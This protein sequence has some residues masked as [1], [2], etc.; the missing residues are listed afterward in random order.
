MR[1][2]TQCHCVN[3]AKCRVE[4]LPPPYIILP[5]WYLAF[6]LFFAAERANDVPYYFNCI[7]FLHHKTGS[8]KQHMQHISA[9]FVHNC[10]IISIFC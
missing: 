3:T 8:E 6:S 4:A 10:F 1:Q 7:F 5:E 2:N 9:L